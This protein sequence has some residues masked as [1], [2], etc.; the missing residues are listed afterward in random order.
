MAS[1]SE[2]G[3]VKNINA[4]AELIVICNNLGAKYSPT[5]AALKLAALGTVLTNAKTTMQKSIATNASYE[6]ARNERAIVFKPLKQLSSKIMSALKSAGANQLSVDNARTWHHKIQ[7]SRA[8]PKKATNT[9]ASS[10]DPS[11]PAAKKTVSSSQQS[12]DKVIEHFE[13]LLGALATEPL[14]APNENEVKVATLQTLLSDMKAKNDAVMS[15]RI[16]AINDNNGRDKVLYDPGTGLADIALAVKVY[17]H[18]V[19]GSNSPEYLNA[20]RLKFT[21]R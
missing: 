13:R 12:F 11:A 5:K 1:T 14:Y 2:T 7:G 20:L 9:S 16:A 15:A 4:F 8:K 19:F 6:K 17:I 3:H 21:K 10:A 18:S